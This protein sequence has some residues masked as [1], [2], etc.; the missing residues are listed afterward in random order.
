[1]KHA[2]LIFAAGILTTFASAAPPFDHPQTG[3]SLPDTI[4][5]LT[6]GDVT[7]YETAPGEA[8]VAVP[9]RNEEVEVTIFIRQID[10]KK[11]TSPAMMV[12]ESLATVK[13]LEASGM[14]TNVKVF[15]STEDRETTGWAKGAFTAR[16]KQAFVMSLIYATIK[17]T[18]AVKARITTAN[19][20]NDS[21]QKFVS[22]F[23]KIVD[24]VKPKP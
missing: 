3:I 13:Q 4:A 15:T 2:L 24:A 12:E 18:H 6:R 11:V 8:G 22:E 21:I 7:P 16:A 10:P 23:Q 5:G 19:P 20:K 17:G 1:M 14:Y 9:Y